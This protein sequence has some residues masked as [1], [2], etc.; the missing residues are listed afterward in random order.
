MEKYIEGLLIF[1]KTVLLFNWLLFKDPNNL[2]LAHWFP[3]S[4]YIYK[5]YFWGLNLYVTL[6]WV[7]KENTSERLHKNLIIEN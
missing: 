6:F 2:I 3:N 5:D 7:Y 4:E 1:C